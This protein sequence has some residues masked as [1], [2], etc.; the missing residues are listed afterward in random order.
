MTLGCLHKLAVAAK[1]LPPQ[2]QRR[3]TLVRSTVFFIHYND[4][5]A[6]K[7]VAEV[8]I[9]HGFLIQQLAWVENAK[10][11]AKI[12]PRL[13]YRRGEQVEDLFG[14]AQTGGFDD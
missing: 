2:R 10:R 11:G 5:C 14:M 13:I 12:D 9:L 7:L 1:M 6:G 4:V 3:S 8:F